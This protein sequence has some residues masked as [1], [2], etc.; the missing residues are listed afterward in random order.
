M[1]R[2]LEQLFVKNYIVRV[3]FIFYF[4]KNFISSKGIEYVAY[5]C[6]N[7]NK[8]WKQICKLALHK[9]EEHFINRI[10]KN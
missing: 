8:L 7:L 2:I 6:K 9:C 3:Y 5:I 4:I 10:E 1:S